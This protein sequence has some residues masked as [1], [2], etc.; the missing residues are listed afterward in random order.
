MSLIAGEGHVSA[1]AGRWADVAAVELDPRMRAL[2]DR[3]LGKADHQHRLV[4]LFA[5]ELEQDE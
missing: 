4:T 2:V 1:P 3:M 5:Q